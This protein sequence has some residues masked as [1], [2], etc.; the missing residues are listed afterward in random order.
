MLVF[1]LTQNTQ[2]MHA[3]LAGHVTLYNMN[4]KWPPPRRMWMLTSKGLMLLDQLV[5][6]QGAMVAYI[7]DF[8]LMMF[9]TLLTI[10]SCCSSDGPAP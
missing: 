7:D 3:A 1:P 9:L 2:R 5:T 4:E 10:S 8:R 6:S